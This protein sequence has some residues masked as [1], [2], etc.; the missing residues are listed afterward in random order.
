MVTR[1]DS[2][3]RWQNQFGSRSKNYIL[4]IL[5]GIFSETP[6]QSISNFMYIYP[7]QSGDTCKWFALS[8]IPYG[9]KRWLL[10]SSKE[11]C[12]YPDIHI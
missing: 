8:T 5:H 7:R 2:A 12:E 11:K 1:M 10:D 3:L 6:R 4:C 9:T